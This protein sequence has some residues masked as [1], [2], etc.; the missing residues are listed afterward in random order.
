MSN[1]DSGIQ[2]LNAVDSGEESVSAIVPLSFAKKNEEWIH[3]S[4]IQDYKNNTTR[5]L[6]VRSRNSN[7][8]LDF[9]R[10]KTSLL[11]EFQE[12]RSGDGKR[13]GLRIHERRSRMV[14]SIRK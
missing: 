11:I 10:K 3:S 13:G 1:V 8:L 9:S 5:F 6:V 7:E 2:F 12:D 4:G 14:Q